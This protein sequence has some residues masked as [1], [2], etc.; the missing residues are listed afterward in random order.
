MRKT[1]LAAVIA[2]TLALGVSSAASTASRHGGPAVNVHRGQGQPARLESRGAP[3]E[4]PRIGHRPPPG[5]Y[6]E[7]CRKKK[8]RH[9]WKI[10]R[11]GQ[12]VP[13]KATPCR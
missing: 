11:N 6:M 2:V 9:E 5:N 8:N 13:P 3:Q 1:I 10:D 7:E 4:T 12:R